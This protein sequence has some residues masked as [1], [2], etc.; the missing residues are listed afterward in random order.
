MQCCYPRNTDSQFTHSAR[1]RCPLP[2]PTLHFQ[3]AMMEPRE[4]VEW[5]VDIRSLCVPTPLKPQRWVTQQPS[6]ATR[7]S[8]T[9]KDIEDKLHAAACRRR[10]VRPP[11][12][13]WNTTLPCES[14]FDVYIRREGS[15]WVPVCVFSH[16][17]TVPWETA[18][19]LCVFDATSRMQ[20]L[21]TRAS[22][23]GL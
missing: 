2:K 22:Y 18:L 23:C 1:P 4:N 3:R 11:G 9:H 20:L 6:T 13:A 19:W 10:E 12:L 8:I 17:A 16:P 5:T 7:A 15:L 14:L 21:A